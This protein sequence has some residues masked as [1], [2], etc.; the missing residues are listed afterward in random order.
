MLNW[1][2]PIY[3]KLTF[4]ELNCEELNSREANSRVLISKKRIS[5]EERKESIVL[6]SKKPKIGRKR[7]ATR[8]LRAERHTNSTS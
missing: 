5:C 3:E 2:E 1:E 8:S 7:I 6:N 4:E